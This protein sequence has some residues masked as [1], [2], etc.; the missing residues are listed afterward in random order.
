MGSLDDIMAAWRFT[1][2]FS[3]TVDDE[4]LMM[5]RG[6]AS[7]RS[8]ERRTTG[9]VADGEEI[10]RTEGGAFDKLWLCSPNSV[11]TILN[12]STIWR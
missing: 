3:T 1:V 8:G 10:R 4:G 12:C 2:E 9:Y 6:A 7:F 11:T 5:K